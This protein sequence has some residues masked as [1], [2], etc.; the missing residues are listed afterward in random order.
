[1]ELRAL[2]GRLLWDVSSCEGTI[3]M[4]SGGPGMLETFPGIAGTR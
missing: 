2:N 4:R 1:M 3:P